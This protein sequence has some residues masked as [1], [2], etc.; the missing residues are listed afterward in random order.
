MSRA[1]SLALV[2][3]TRLPVPLRFDPTPSEWGRSVLFFPLVGL[4]LGL[5]LAIPAPLLAALDPTIGAALLLTWWVLLTGGLHL[6]GLAD[7][8]DAW[9]GGAGDRGKTLAIMK[10]ARCGPMAVLAVVLVLLNKFAALQLL[11]VQQAWP[12][13]LVAPVLGRAALLFLL[14]TTPYVRPGGIG[15]AYAGYLPRTAAIRLLLGGGVLLPGLFGWSGAVLLSV[16]GL[17]LLGWRRLLLQRLGG[18]TGDTLGAAGEL[19]ET[20]AIMIPGLL[21]A[22]GFS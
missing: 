10:D 18:T 11:L 13:L 19:V 3:L 17:M 14:L 20:V 7:T 5:L 6:D 21:K 4:L 9:V 8:A 2:F 15:A 16:L 12:V 22:A 1:F